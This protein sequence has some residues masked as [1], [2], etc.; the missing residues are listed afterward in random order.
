MGYISIMGSI[1]LRLPDDLEEK[2]KKIADE[3][4]RTLSNLI[5]LIL[6]Q[7][8]EQNEKKP[9]PKTPKK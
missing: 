5:R 9:I 1:G 7:W 2:L 3:D 8:L 6:I 4:H